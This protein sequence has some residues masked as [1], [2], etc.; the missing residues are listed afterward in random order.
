MTDVTLS[1]EPILQEL[2]QSSQYK[3]TVLIST[4]VIVGVGYL[5]S[6]I[7]PFIKQKSG[8]IN[9]KEFDDFEAARREAVR[10]VTAKDQDGN[11]L[12]LS[13]SRGLR[14]IIDEMRDINKN[15]TH[16]V[17]HQS[18][19]MERVSTDHYENKRRIDKLEKKE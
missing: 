19:W 15:I 4:L 6:K 13:F 10:I 12:M 14:E 2:I 11:Y 16:L 5:L 3:D 8:T 1:T 17:N 7:L 18:E 9:K